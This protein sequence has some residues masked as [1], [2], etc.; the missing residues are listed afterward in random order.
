[1]GGISRLQEVAGSRNDGITTGDLKEILMCLLVERIV[2][3]LGFNTTP[4]GVSLGVAN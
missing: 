1:M 3:I 4:F 2:R